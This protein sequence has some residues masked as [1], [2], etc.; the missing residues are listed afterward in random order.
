VKKVVLVGLVA[1]AVGAGI[2]LRAASEGTTTPPRERSLEESLPLVSVSDLPPSETPGGKLDEYLGE[3]TLGKWEGVALLSSYSLETRVVV[4]RG[5]VAYRHDLTLV[6]RDQD[7]GFKV[8]TTVK[9]GAP[10][11]SVVRAQRP[12][13]VLGEPPSS[14][15]ADA[16]VVPAG[17]FKCYWSSFQRTKE[18]MLFQMWVTDALPLPVKLEISGPTWHSETVLAAV[19][20]R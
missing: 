3:L 2:Y 12:R 10:S 19:P 11:T 7:L 20:P 6:E 17:T 4:Q 15:W 16:V 18:S 5:Y 9:G 1:A 13:V 8:V 14:P